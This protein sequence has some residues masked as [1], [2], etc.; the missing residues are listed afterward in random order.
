MLCVTGGCPAY[1]REHPACKEWSSPTS[2]S[3]TQVLVSQGVAR[4]IKLSSSVAGQP[5]HLPLQFC[6]VSVKSVAA[7]HHA[8]YH[9]QRF[10]S[11][12]H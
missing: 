4:C 7:T 6:P 1:Q 2:T 10:H 5:E 9:V 8:T 3:G 11:S 12:D